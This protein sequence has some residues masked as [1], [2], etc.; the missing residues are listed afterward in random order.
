MVTQQTPLPADAGSNALPDAGVI[1]AG[2][3]TGKVFT[4]EEV[5]LLFATVKL[6]KASK[7]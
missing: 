7:D 5:W 3:K 2:E 6:K 1:A 4:G